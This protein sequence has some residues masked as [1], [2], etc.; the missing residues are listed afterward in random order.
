M[1]TTKNEVF[2]GLY[3]CENCYLVGGNNLWCGMIFPDGG[4]G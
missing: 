3:K 1:T 4:G 2:I